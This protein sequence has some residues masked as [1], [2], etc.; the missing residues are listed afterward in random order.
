MCCGNT[1][2]KRNNNDD[3]DALTRVDDILLY[4]SAHVSRTEITNHGIVH[5]P[6]FNMDLYFAGK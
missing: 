1:A 2:Q 5:S 4:I 6:A 3:D